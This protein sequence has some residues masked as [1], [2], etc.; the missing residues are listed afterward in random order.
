MSFR[1]RS[2]NWLLF[3][4]VLI[5]FAG[6]CSEDDT[7]GPSSD[8]DVRISRVEIDQ[9][10]LGPGE[11]TELRVWVV[12]GADP[13]NPVEGVPVRFSE[14][15]SSGSGSFSK[16]EDLS[17]A[18]G[19]VTSDFTPSI[20]QGQVTLKIT[21]G[22]D[23]EYVT[24]Q[25]T[26]APSNA[27]QIAMSTAS[28]ATSLPADGSATL[29][30]T[31]RVTR[32]DPAVPMANQRVLLTA[33]DQFLDLDGDGRFNGADQLLP[34]GDLNGDG[35]WNAEGSIPSEVT[36]DASG[37]ASF[38]YV[39]GTH[40]GNVYLKAT[41]AGVSKDLMLYQHPTSVQV[42]LSA[43]Q[44]ELLANGVNST[45]VTATVSDWGGSSI[46]GVI[47]RFVA[48]EVFTDVDL[49][50]YF[51]AGVD[52]YEDANENGRWDAIG[53]I[54]ST[55]TT[56]GNGT[57]R[58]SYTA[59]LREG[60]VSIHVT[61]SSG[62]ATTEVQLLR[63][64]PADRVTFR[65]STPIVLPADGISVAH[66]E[67]E[68]FDISSAP[69]AG[70]KIRLVAGER[71][72][73]RNG[74][75]AFTN[76]TDVLLDDANGDGVWSP[77][78]S[79]E[80]EVYT[81][82]FGTAD[83]EYTAGD[84]A[85]AVWIRA[86]ADGISVERAVTL[87][88]LPSDGIDRIELTTDQPEIGVQGTGALEQTRIRARG[89]DRN[90]NPVGAAL[91]I[92]FS[93]ARGPAGT[94][95]LSGTA[96]VTVN[97][98]AEGRA[99]VTIASGTVSGTVEIRAQAPGGAANHTTVSV[100]AGPPAYIGVG[101]ELCN[102]LGWSRV[103][104]D[105][106]IVAVVRDVYHNP[107][108]N[109]TTV[110]F[111]ANTGAVYGNAGLGTGITENGVTSGTWLSDADN[112]STTAIV[113]GST[114]GGTVVNSTAFI[115]SDDPAQ[116]T[117]LSP[118]SDT[119]SLLADGAGEL[120]IWVEVLDQNDMYTLPAELSVEA[121]FGSVNMDE[122]GDGCATSVARGVYRSTTLDRDYSVTV[123]D[124][125]IGASDIFSVSTGYGGGSDF[126]T[127]NLLTSGAFRD[128]SDLELGGSV[129]I[130]G[131]GIFQV[132]IADRFGNPLGG[133]TLEASVSDG[134]VT[135]MAPTDTWGQSI[136]TFTAPG[137]E[138]PVTLTVLDTDPNY[139]GLVLTTVINV[140]P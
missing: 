98:D 23:I 127:V 47:L 18:Q 54:A 133:H 139:G 100:A 24:L 86:A 124:D 48:G 2:W 76:G 50:G 58:V 126:L 22:D 64:P 122:S 101:A 14:L 78:G 67:L 56:D 134:A 9:A 62:V 93:V 52:S 102:V 123:P 85:G 60:P 129:S 35:L 36:T 69:I 109:G 72:D 65:E 88:D 32:G 46:N 27:V 39:S 15:L 130:G 25:V 81:D 114:A 57:A 132:T 77:V 26:A 97:T 110:Y 108:R 70:K 41:A 105:N 87:Q 79:I 37:Q 71:F 125:G 95:F 113:T 21:A 140:T 115:V 96:P 120:V 53:T 68:V 42:R 136:G 63:V 45:F 94:G 112:L 116:V 7:T 28:S 131:S 117:I 4:P 59:G 55:A 111:T 103:N 6:G 19:R 99:S 82:E 10:M 40:E 43:D 92:V 104:V 106:Q 5:A 83:F 107:V 128:N 75:G 90:G 44:R 118:S 119:V 13:G 135:A 66:G 121:E 33:G 51:T 38:L 34:T 20:D 84:E 138:G 91:P 31:V 16:D 29:Q 1:L 73:D 89:L 3:V 30:V 61:S 49:D 137:V 12:R 11:S 17:D 80:A 8:N 74:D